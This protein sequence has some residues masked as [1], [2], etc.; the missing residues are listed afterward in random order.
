[1]LSLPAPWTLLPKLSEIPKICN[2]EHDGAALFVQTFLL[3]GIV[4]SYLP[5]H[6]NIISKGSSEGFSPWFLL[7]GCTSANSG[8]IN[9]LALQWESVKCCRHVGFLLCYESLGGIE[10]VGL[11]WFVFTIILVLFLIYFPPHLKYVEY[12]ATAHPGH[13]K[14]CEC[15]PCEA[16][17]A[18]PQVNTT[19]EWKLAIALAWVVLIHLLLCLF[20]TTILLY[21]SP[22]S[23]DGVPADRVFVWTTFL[24]LC[25]TSLAFIQYMPQLLHTYRTKLVG[26]LSIPAMLIQSPGAALMVY[27]IASKP[28]TNWTSWLVYATAGCLQATLLT[29]CLL[30]KA[31]QKRLGID[32]FGNPLPDAPE[33]SHFQH[34]IPSSVPDYGS[35][36]QQPI[37]SAPIVGAGTEAAEEPGRV[38]AVTRAVEDAIESTPLLPEQQSS[39][40]TKQQGWRKWL[41]L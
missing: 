8:L 10:I 16:A 27:I 19:P 32:D 6:L 35:N 7:L 33:G 38:V 26:A 25:S 41:A 2:F 14:N 28:G 37:Y 5:Q 22:S 21:S 40:E 17:R 3:V 13:P 34:H 29:M 11:Q 30:W 36:L 20:I 24:G 31:R 15:E 4:V 23:P 9:V 18:G 12:R 39:S 1:M